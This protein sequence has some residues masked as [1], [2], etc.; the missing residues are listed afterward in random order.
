MDTPSHQ[1]QLPWALSL[2]FPL[3]GEEVG[4]LISKCSRAQWAARPFS[5]A[6]ASLSGQGRVPTFN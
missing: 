4:P 5:P 6:A 2:R 3:V 1:P